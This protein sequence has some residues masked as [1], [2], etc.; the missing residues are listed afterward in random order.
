MVE[1]LRHVDELNGRLTN[2]EKDSIT[3]PGLFRRNNYFVPVLYMDHTLC[4]L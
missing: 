2:L 3:S 4:Q 1:N